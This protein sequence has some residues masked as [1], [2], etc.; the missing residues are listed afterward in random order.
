MWIA[1]SGERSL[2]LVDVP[3]GD[4]LGSVSEIVRKKPRDPS[5]QKESK[6]G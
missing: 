5:I 6:G 3:A 1:A 4:M 2:I